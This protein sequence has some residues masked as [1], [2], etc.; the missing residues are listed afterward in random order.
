MA[1]LIKQRKY[2][3]NILLEY[4]KL[5]RPKQYIKNGFV[6][7]ALIFSNNI[8]NPS[9][10]LKSILSF[11]AFCMISS[12]AYILNDILDIEKDKMHPKKCKRPLA[13]GSIGKKG[14]FH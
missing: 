1:S 13:S 12:S 10:A 14:Q 5:M 11:I 4:I 8:L 2:N 6:L 3:R 7:A 9:L